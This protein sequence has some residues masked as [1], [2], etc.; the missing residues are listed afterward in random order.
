MLENLDLHTYNNN[1]PIQRKRRARD[2]HDTSLFETDQFYFN[3]CFAQSIQ[4]HN[5]LHNSISQLIAN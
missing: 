5:K 3:Y 4:L 1:A 2:Y